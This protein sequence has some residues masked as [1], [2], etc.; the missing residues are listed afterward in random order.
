MSESIVER[1]ILTVIEPTIELDPLEIP[2]AES[3]TE[4][5][6]GLTMKE[7]PSL[8]QDFILKMVIW[9]K[10]ISDHREMKLHLSQ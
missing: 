7:K 10:L 3:G 6:D 8:L 4:N 1:N 5:S 9:Y 2:D